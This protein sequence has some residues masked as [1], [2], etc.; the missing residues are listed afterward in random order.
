MQIEGRRGMSRGEIMCR[1]VELPVTSNGDELLAPMGKN[2]GTGRKK[3][4]SERG[5]S[6]GGN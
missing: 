1:G 2:E 4:D 6:A 5:V 3:R